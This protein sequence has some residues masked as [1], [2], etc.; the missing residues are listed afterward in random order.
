MQNKSY[1]PKLFHRN[2]LTKLHFAYFSHRNRSRSLAR[3][4]YRISLPHKSKAEGIYLLPFFKTSIIQTNMDFFFPCSEILKP[5]LLIRNFR[6][7]CPS[8]GRK[9]SFNSIAST[10]FSLS[11]IS[12]LTIII[13]SMTC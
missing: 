13:H 4:L 6:H 11:Y 8:Y 1:F 2:T 7:N 10:S 5:L 12:F 9:G 3:I